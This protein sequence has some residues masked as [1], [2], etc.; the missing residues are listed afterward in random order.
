MDIEYELDN[1]Q[2][3]I[4]CI[5][6]DILSMPNCDNI[7]FLQQQLDT[8]N[9]NYMKLLDR[10]NGENARY[11]QIIGELDNLYLL[12]EANYDNIEKLSQAVNNNANNANNCINCNRLFYTCP[13]KIHKLVIDKDINLIFITII[14]AGGAGGMGCVKDMYYYSGGGGGAGSCYIKKPVEV[15]NGTILNIK[16]GKGGTIKDNL[17]GEDS[18]VEVNNL[19]TDNAIVVAQGGKNGCLSYTNALCCMD[20]TCENI[21]IVCGGSGGKNN[22]CV[23]CFDG[24]DGDPGQI[25]V[26]SQFAANGGNG[27]TSHFYN[28]G[29]GGGNYFNSGGIGG[30]YLNLNNNVIITNPNDPVYPVNPVYPINVDDIIVGKDGKYGSG[31]GGSAPRLNIDINAKLSGDGGNG[32]VMIE[33]C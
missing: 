10:Q 20:G 13:N 22:T 19:Y 2:N 6:K 17:D 4:C 5:E 27:G 1:L 18:Y 9:K 21:H 33:W 3:Q 24:C 26:P 15:R 31:G 23:T 30:N 11:K 8:I 7:C 25:S 16:V 12:L 29:N 28:G 14:G 32:F